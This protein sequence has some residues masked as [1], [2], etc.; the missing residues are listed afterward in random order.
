M[1]GPD[2]NDLAIERITTRDQ[3]Y[4]FRRM[5]FPTFR[6]LLDFEQDAPA[7]V[8]LGARDGDRPC[9]LLLASIEE[10]S[11]ILSV[12]VAQTE[13]RRG[14]ARTLIKEALR[15]LRRTST[16]E[17][18]V[19]YSEELGARVALESLLAEQAFSGPEVRSRQYVL[20]ASK[21]IPARWIRARRLPSGYKVML[22][23]D[24]PGDILSRV[25]NNDPSFDWVKPYLHPKLFLDGYEPKTSFALLQNGEL[26]AW[27]LNHR[28][29]NMVR[30]S[31]AYAHPEQQRGAWITALFRESTLAILDNGWDL[32]SYTINVS[33]TGFWAF[34][35][36]YMRP[37]AE[38]VVT[39]YEMQT[40]LETS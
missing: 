38:K 2:Q 40:L 36:R 6:H 11:E 4:G 28:L 10:T 1:T 17:I 33:E 24:L 30:F 15:H 13:R 39:F 23:R 14:V 35:D 9:G 29:G 32:T 25:E 21:T 19:R 5:T 31:S 34:A 37:L 16:T 8:A 3:S 22:W 12:F 20:S 26:R 7:I 27:T 18:V